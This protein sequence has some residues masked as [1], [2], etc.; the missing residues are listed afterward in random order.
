VV[1]ALG[2]AFDACLE[3]GFVGLMLGAWGAFPPGVV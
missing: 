1:H 2:E 3:E